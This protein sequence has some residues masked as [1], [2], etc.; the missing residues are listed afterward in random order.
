[1]E[2]QAVRGSC[3]AWVASARCGGAWMRS[4]RTSVLTAHLW[5]SHEAQ[6]QSS[7][8]KLDV[9]CQHNHLEWS[10]AEKSLLG[11]MQCRCLMMKYWRDHTGLHSFALQRSL[12]ELLAGVW[13]LPKCCLVSFLLEVSSQKHHLSIL[14]KLSRA[15][16]DVTFSCL[17]AGSAVLTGCV[18][19]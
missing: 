17:S 4:P 1:M 6:N 3:N 11:T 5:D 16:R 15:R 13:Q 2:W 18:L 8:E 12:G 9:R 10:T 7:W 14:S 19:C